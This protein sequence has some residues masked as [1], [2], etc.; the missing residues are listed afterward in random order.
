MR[1]A[2]KVARALE[3]GAALERFRRNVEEQGGDPRVCDDPA[4]SRT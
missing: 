1:R 4:A 3:S 2:Q